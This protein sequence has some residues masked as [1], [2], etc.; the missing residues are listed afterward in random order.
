[1][2]SGLSEGYLPK[3]NFIVAIMALFNTIQTY[4]N[5]TLTRR[6]Y[7][8]AQ[9]Q[10][11]SLGTRLFGTWTLVS[12]IVRLYAAYHISNSI[13][14]EITLWT[15]YIAAFHFITEWLIFK[16]TKFSVSLVG[17]LIVSI[18]SIIWMNLSRQ[19]YIH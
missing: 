18:S 8:T 13:V 10:V 3:W 11:N 14:Y 1:M 5:L 17:P 16:S 2:L 4:V 6:V 12:A 7:N 15:Y 9:N 19:N